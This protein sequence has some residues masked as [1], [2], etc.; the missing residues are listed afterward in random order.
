MKHSAMIKAGLTGEVKLEDL[1][2]SLEIIENKLDSEIQAKQKTIDRQE[3]ELKHLHLLIESKDKL[4][5]E[6]NEKLAECNRNN[7]GN[8]QLINKLLNDIGRLNQDIEWYKKTYESRSFLGTL[9]E[10]LFLKK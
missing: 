6:I 2:Q 9:K 1:Q 4:L 3:T 10:K 5:R 8:R 7:E